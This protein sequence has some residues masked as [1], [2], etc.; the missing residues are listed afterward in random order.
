VE[1][2]P[3]DL[4]RFAA[5]Q[6]GIS[7]QAINR[8]IK[9]LVEEGVL[10]QTGSTS[11]KQYGLKILVDKGFTF[12]LAPD[13]NED[14][15]WR[16]HVR[17]LL[18]DA[19]PNVLDIC[20]Y[21]TTEMLNNA[22]S[23]SEGSKVSIFVVLTAASIKILVTDD[24]IG[25]F[26]KVRNALQ[27]NDERQA[28]LELAKGKL[29][30]DPAHHSGEGVFFTSR[31]FDYFSILSRHLAFISHGAGSDWLMEDKDF[32]IKGTGVTMQ[33][34]WESDRRIEDVFAKCQSNGDMTFLRTHVPVVLAQYGEETLV[35]RSQAK[36]LLA[37][38]ERFK[39]V[40]LDFSGVSMIGQAFADE[41]FRVFRARHPDIHISSVN[42]NPEIDQM[43]KRVEV[44]TVLLSEPGAIQFPFLFKIGDWVTVKS[45]RLL[46]GRIVQGYFVG[47]ASEGSYQITYDV[48]AGNGLILRA[49]ESD[50]E[51]LDAHP[52]A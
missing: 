8:R 35:S 38:F 14:D 19:S 23:H 52:D 26:E 50:F 6:F 48:E 10:T 4:A 2:H 28:I 45:N 17:P 39:D 21:G 47:Q 46:N 29:T 3:N 36:R 16:D 24:G 20:V 13:L 51:R 15:I 32:D 37:R 34:E 27:L 12:P 43:I 1:R 49:A 11:A 30:T 44:R 33:I 5:D 25:I 18:K 31:S 41:V 22:I 7:R 40:I 9:K 42:T